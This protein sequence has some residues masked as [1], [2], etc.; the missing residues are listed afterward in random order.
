AP[1]SFVTIRA[2]LLSAACGCTHALTQ[3]FMAAFRVEG[4][5]SNVLSDAKSIFIGS[6]MCSYAGS[7]RG[8]AAV[9]PAELREA[10]SRSLVDAKIPIERRKRWGV[11]TEEKYGRIVARLEWPLPYVLHPPL[12]SLLG[13]ARHFI[14]NLL[15]CSEIIMDIQCDVEHPVAEDCRRPF[16]LLMR[17]LLQLITLISELFYKQAQVL[18][19]RYFA[20]VDASTTVDEARG[21][22]DALHDRLRD[23]VGSSGI[24]KMVRELVD[25]FCKMAEEIHLFLLSGKITSME[26]FKWSKV[27]ERERAMLISMGENMTKNVLADLLT[28]C[29][30]VKWVLI[31]EGRRELSASTFSMTPAA[32]SG[33]TGAAGANGTAGATTSPP[34]PIPAPR[35]SRPAPPRPISI[36]AQRELNLSLPLSG[37]THPPSSASKQNPLVMP[38]SACPTMSGWIHKVETRPL[39]G[40]ITRKRYWFALAEGSPYLYCSH[41]EEHVFETGCNTLREEWM[42]ALQE[43]RKRSWNTHIDIDKEIHSLT[44]IAASPRSPFDGHFL[45][46]GMERTEEEKE[47]EEEEEESTAPFTESVHDLLKELGPT[48]SIEGEE[49]EEGEDA[50]DIDASDDEHDVTVI[51]EG[52]G[53]RP[54]SPPISI[55]TSPSSTFYVAP[56]GSLNEH[57]FDMPKEIVG[58]ETVLSRLAENSIERPTKR[59]KEMA[60]RGLREL[61]ERGRSFTGAKDCEQCRRMHTLLSESESCRLEMEELVE[62]FEEQS[63]SQRNMLRRATK[64]NETLRRIASLTDKEQEEINI[65]LEKEEEL[66]EARMRV[67]ELQRRLQDAE[68]QNRQLE[69]TVSGLQSDVEAF[70]DSVRTKEELIMRLAE[71]SEETER[72]EGGRRLSLIGDVEVPEGIP[73]EDSSCV[74]MEEEARRIYEEQAVR[75]VHEMRD[76]V[77]GYRM[78]NEAL[79][80]E[81]VELHNMLTAYEEK[82]RRLTRAHFETQACYYQLKSRYIMVLNHFKSPEKPGKIMEPGVLRELIDEANRTPRSAR[83]EKNGA[84]TDKLGFYVAEEAST[85]AGGD[86][87]S[88]MFET[89]A[90]CQK[91]ADELMEASQLEQSEEYMKWLQ[92]WDAFLVNSVNTKNAV[93]SSPELKAL[94]RTGIP[95]AH[96]ARVWV[97]LVSLHVRDRQA[98]MGNGYYECMLKKAK[99]KKEEGVFDSAIKQIDLD[100]ARTLPTNKYFEDPSSEKVE[101]LRR[102]LYAF[103]YHNTE[104]GYCQGLNRLA[105][106]GLLYLTEEDAFWFLTACVEILQ[107]PGY[108]TSTLIGAVAD[109]KVDLSLFTLSWFLTCFVDILPHSVYLNIFDVFLYEGN[110]ILFRF[111]LALLKLGES[112]VLQCKTIGTVHACLS[113]ASDFVPNFKK[114]AQVAFNELNPFPQKSIE[115]KRQAYLTELKGQ[116]YR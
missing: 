55:P 51:S 100:L 79:N 53:K 40:V 3:E 105:A 23:L 98:E 99:R 8:G 11:D 63:K 68:E 42:R 61:R 57:S 88:D 85:S 82:E 109:Q 54:M 66:N 6:A 113:R 94:V 101:L 97:R 116:G 31:R 91:R 84:A 48:T 60:S 19:D 22:A 106:I 115:Q 50:D 33:E 64:E 41:N 34:P 37:A 59:A 83:K 70:R 107:P 89:A 25:M 10:F 44:S 38:S 87:R 46:G 35:K 2:A 21:H 71:Q 80:N 9:R 36:A 26:V 62:A 67:N 45:D 58:P 90:D 95:L 86:T 96:R 110:K 39:L 81:I 114:L 24:R 47:G 103:R 52:R 49:K 102:V 18:V 16:L 104:V 74:V 1:L 12:L 43:T 111:A 77:E 65:M 7:L 4:R 69:A 27:V 20:R 14:L 93:A 112:R 13:D 30:S 15:R 5:L 56:D 32:T 108:Y 92:S 72:E 29:S 78:Q 73:M 17:N 75:D 76:L 28:V